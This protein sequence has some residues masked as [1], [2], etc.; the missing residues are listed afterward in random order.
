MKMGCPSCHTPIEIE[1]PVRVE[2]KIVKE[3]CKCGITDKYR[4]DRTVGR[5]ISFIAFSIAIMFVG[6]CWVSNHFQTK[7]IELVREKYEVIKHPS[8]WKDGED[9]YKVFEKSTPTPTP[10]GHCQK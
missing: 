10:C 8:L 5:T 2:E 9:T 7:Q 6:G 4:S 1:L 3:P